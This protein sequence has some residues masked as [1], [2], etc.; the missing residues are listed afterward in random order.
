[1]LRIGI[2]I[3]SYEKVREFE[4][5]ES[6]AT[7]INHLLSIFWDSNALKSVIEALHRSGFSRDDIGVLS[8][9]EGLIDR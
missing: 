9:E 2:V 1:L 8:V 5:E 3:C 4:N 6:I 7:P